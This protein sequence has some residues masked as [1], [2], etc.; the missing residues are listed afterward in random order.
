M[1]KFLESNK[2]PKLNQEETQNQN[3]PIASKKIELIARKKKKKKHTMYKKIS[4]LDGF[5]GKCWQVLK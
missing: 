2:L 5:I 3:K 4:G 1:D